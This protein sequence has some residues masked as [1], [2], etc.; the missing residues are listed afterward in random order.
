MT[1]NYRICV[2]P[3]L[4]QCVKLGTAVNAC[5]PSI[6]RHMKQ[7]KLVYREKPSTYPQKRANSKC[8]VFIHLLGKF[9]SA[10]KLYFNNSS[11]YFCFK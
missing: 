11:L 7:E 3:T 8:G 5:N 6:L 10:T 9:W 2:M 4:Y 1:Q